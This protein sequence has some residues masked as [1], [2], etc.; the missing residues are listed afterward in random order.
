VSQ[1]RQFN[2]E[3]TLVSLG[4]QGE[5]IQNQ[6]RPVDHPTAYY[7]LKI[8]LLN[9]RD[10]LINNN[11]VCAVRRDRFCDLPRFAT[12]NISSRFRSPSR[13]ANAGHD[14]AAGRLRQTSQ[15]VKVSVN[16]TAV[17]ALMYEDSTFR[18]IEM[19]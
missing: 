8:A 19:R 17:K 2:L 3:L 1:L 9:R 16:D 5:N 15:F 10:R 11:Q 7:F 13:G 4:P 14:A 18:L 12:S 6:S